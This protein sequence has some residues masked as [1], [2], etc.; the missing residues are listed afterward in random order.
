MKDELSEIY[1][2]ES[3]RVKYYRQ[4][5]YEVACYERYGAK[6]TITFNEWLEMKGYGREDNNNEDNNTE[7]NRGGDTIS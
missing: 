3:Q 4:Y 1:N 7:D 6:N 5:L 2:G